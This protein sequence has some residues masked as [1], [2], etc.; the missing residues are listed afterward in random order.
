MFSKDV[1][2]QLNDNAMI[3]SNTYTSDVADPR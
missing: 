3:H 2:P 1:S